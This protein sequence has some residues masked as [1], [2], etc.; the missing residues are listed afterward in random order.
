MGDEEISIYQCMNV[1][2]G[3]WGFKFVLGIFGGGKVGC[4]RVDEMRERGEERSRWKSGL[5]KEKS[6]ED[7][8]GEIRIRR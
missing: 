3:G 6:G 2:I 7:K 8:R 4:K 1:G 5:K